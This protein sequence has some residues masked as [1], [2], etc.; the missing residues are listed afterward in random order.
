MEVENNTVCYK[1]FATERICKL[2]AN[3]DAEIFLNK[4]LRMSSGRLFNAKMASNVVQS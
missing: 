1:C 4:I 2:L 3:T